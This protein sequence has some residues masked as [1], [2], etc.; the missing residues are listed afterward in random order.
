LSIII[1]STRPDLTAEQYDQVIARL[2][3]AG[4][5]PS[6]CAVHI[7]GPSPDGWQ[8]TS[9]WESSEAAARFNNEVLRPILHE[10]GI[11]APAK[12]PVIYPLHTLVQ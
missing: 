2:N 4:G 12:P 1:V 11:T 8:V 9:V 7:A 10:L 5:F 3:L 6:S